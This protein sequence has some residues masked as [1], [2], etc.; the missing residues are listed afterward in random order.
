MSD[1]D[2]APTD[3]RGR[4]LSKLLVN[5][6]KGVLYRE[7]DESLWSALLELQGPARDHFAQIGIRVEIDE[8]EGYA[9]LR[10]PTEA[11]SVDEPDAPRLIARRQLTYEVS[12]LVALLR[13]RMAEFDA[14]GEEAKLV[15]SRDEI[16]EM[17]RPFFPDAADEVKFAGA[18]WRYIA[19]VEKMGFLRAMKDSVGDYEVCRIVKAFVDAQWLGELDKRLESYRKLREENQ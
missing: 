9:Y 2:K 6:Y 13:K 16:V 4:L 14:S 1:Q 19:S 11:E 7:R 5:L 18:I 17:M 12:L 15:M 10:Y 8:D 3:E